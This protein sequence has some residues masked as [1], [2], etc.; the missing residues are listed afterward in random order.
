MKASN[1]I[2]L[3]MAAVGAMIG[4]AACGSQSDTSS[5]SKTL[6]LWS[7]QEIPATVVKSWKESPFHTQLAKQ[8]K[9]KVNWQF[10]ASGADFSQAFN[11]LITQ[12]KLLDMIW[13]GFLG[14]A[15]QMISDGVLMDLSKDLPKKAPHYWAFLKAHPEYMRAMKTDSGKIYM[16]GFFRE[17]PQQ[18]TFIGPEIRQD[19]L[20]ANNLKMPTNIAE[21]EN[22]F[23]VFHD[24]YNATWGFVPDWTFNPGFA[25]AFGAHAGLDPNSYIDGKKVKFAQTQ[26]EWKNYIAWLHK[27][28]AEGLIDK[29]FVTAD[30]NSLQTKATTDKVGVIFNLQSVVSKLNTAA[31]SNKSSAKWVGAPYPNQA[32]GEKPTA[33]YMIDMYNT[34]GVGITTSISKDKLDAAYKWIDYP[35]TKEGQLYWNYGEKGV[36]WEMK[37]GKPTFTDKMTKGK[38]DLLTQTQ[39]YTGNTGNG[40]GVQLLDMIRQRTDASSFKAG[41]TWYNGNKQVRESMYPSAVSYTRQESK[42]IAQIMNT[43]GTY[44]KERAIKFITGELPMSQFDSF[45]TGLKKQGVDRYLKIQQDAYDRYLKRQ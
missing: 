39:L 26:P 23:K 1:K 43:M 20:D 31:A 6:T 41:E 21:W 2:G 16:A 11:L 44:V 19:W 38:Y 9:I 37:D 42:E 28:Y 3:L 35:Y 14:S 8:T 15:D 7:D 32:N 24:K 40:L 4:L 25:G 30:G 45:M 29:D 13:H 27:M 10:P 34:Q 33:I 5:S 36:S 18:T 17:T 22:V 12:K